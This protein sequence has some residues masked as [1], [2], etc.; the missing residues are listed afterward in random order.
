MYLR[1]LV[2][3]NRA[4][5]SR[6]PLHVLFNVVHDVPFP[7]LLLFPGKK[8]QFIVRAFAVVCY[9]LDA[10][11]VLKWLDLAAL[12]VVEAY[13]MCATIYERLSSIAAR[14]TN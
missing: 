11:E 2:V 1:H 10:L 5:H 14:R 8:K 4:K 9:F 3:R 13:N 7:L 6:N 12:L